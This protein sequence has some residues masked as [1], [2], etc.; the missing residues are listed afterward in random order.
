MTSTSVLSGEVTHPAFQPAT[1]AT[2]GR[3]TE[4]M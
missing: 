1:Y 3:T 4:S 2:D